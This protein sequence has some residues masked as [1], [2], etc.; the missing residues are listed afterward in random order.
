MLT[1]VTKM[2]KTSCVANSNIHHYFTIRELNISEA[3]PNPA[4]RRAPPDPGHAAARKPL[5]PP[6]A[7][8]VVKSFNSWAFKRAQPDNPARLAE[9]VAVALSR[10]SPTP[11]L[12][13]WGRGPREYLAQP[14]VECL[15]YITQLVQRIETVYAPGA[16]VTL[17]FTDTHARL[18]GYGESSTSHYFEQV[19][20]AA[21]ERGFMSVRLGDLVAAAQGRIGDEA[22]T[23][24]L[25]PEMLARLEATAAKWYRGDGD[26]RRGA[27]LYLRANLIERRAVEIAY[28]EAIFATF[29]GPEL[30]GLFPPSLP[31]FYMYSLRR[32]CAVKPWFM[33]AG[34]EDAQEIV[35]EGG[36]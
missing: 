11:I 20:T 22:Q 27:E 8:D 5:N 21:A 2:V 18:N 28:P 24:P 35:V 29:N 25:C 31:I 36:R 12:F 17:L 4:K 19:A 16:A 13:Y 7:A 34:A 33:A 10:S 14:E 3:A 30:R 6:T 1:M 15:R 23:A 26:A 9:V 32:G